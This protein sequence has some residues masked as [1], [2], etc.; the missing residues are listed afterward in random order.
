MH[1]NFFVRVES[2]AT[3]GLHG[4]VIVA[5]TQHISTPR[6]SSRL[7]AAGSLWTCSRPRA[8]STARWLLKTSH[9]PSQPSSRNSS[10]GSSACSV[11]CAA[12]SGALE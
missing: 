11:T 9:R 10:S 1:E 12:A 3:I 5:R 2:L 8:N 4:T 7:Q 6:T